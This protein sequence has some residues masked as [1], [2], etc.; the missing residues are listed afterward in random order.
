M[1][2]KFFVKYETYKRKLAICNALQRHNKPTET[3]EMKSALA[4][5]DNEFRD[6]VELVVQDLAKAAKAKA[7]A[8]AQ[9]EKK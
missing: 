1:L 9:A 3:A 5:L 4:A 2:E 6:C 7:A 8:A